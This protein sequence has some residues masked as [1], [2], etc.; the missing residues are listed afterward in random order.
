MYLLLFGSKSAQTPDNTRYVAVWHFHAQHCCRME[1]ESWRLRKFPKYRDSEGKAFSY[2]PPNVSVQRFIDEEI[3]DQYGDALP[4]WVCDLVRLQ[5]HASTAGRHTLPLP[6]KITLPREQ[7]RKRR[8]SPKSE[9]MEQLRDQMRVM[10]LN[11]DNALQDNEAV[12]ARVEVCE[13][14]Y[15]RVC[16]ERG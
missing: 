13:E 2:P 9:E 15:L 3:R 10:Q 16:L 11:L 4:R 7:S 12:S 6:I 14:K 1:D 5:R 8:G